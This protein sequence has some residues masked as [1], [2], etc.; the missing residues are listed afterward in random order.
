MVIHSANDAT[1]TLTIARRDI[2]ADL[3]KIFSDLDINAIYR[4]PN[5]ILFSTRDFAKTLRILY[6]GSY[7]SHEM[8]E[9]ALKLLSKVEFK[10]G[11]RQGVD[12]KILISNKFGQRTRLTENNEVAS[13][14]LHDCGIVYHQHEPYILCVMSKG[15][16][17]D[18][19]SSFIGEVSKTIFD[20]MQE[21]LKK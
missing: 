7:L 14:Q 11:L 10:E 2:D 5:E 16:E 3:E 9:K 19:L 21:E 8:S 6:N 1:D 17:Y 18:K 12:E 13:R 4:E 20:T 15:M